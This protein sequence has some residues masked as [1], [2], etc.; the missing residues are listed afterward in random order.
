M[1]ADKSEKHT[2]CTYRACN[3]GDVYSILQSDVQ[4]QIKLIKKRTGMQYIRIWNILSKEYCFD[5]NDRYNFR[6]L[7]QVLDFLLENDMRPYMELG[8][9]PSLFMYTPE[10]SVKQEKTEKAEQ[11]K[12][13]IFL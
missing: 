3:I 1:Y 9:K 8:N 5:E 10:R 12:Y 6:K 2:S 7:D 11:Y 4:E 13:E